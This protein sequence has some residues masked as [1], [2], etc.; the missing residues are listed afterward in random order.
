[1]PHQMRNEHSWCGNCSCAGLDHRD[2]FMCHRYAP[3]PGVQD[4]DSDGSLQDVCWPVIYD[5]FWCGEWDPHHQLEGLAPSN[6]DNIVKQVED[7]RTAERD[8]KNKAAIE[9]EF[10]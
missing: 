10:L 1:M 7:A 6:A 9:S 8:A 2:N 4:H 3:R 5:D